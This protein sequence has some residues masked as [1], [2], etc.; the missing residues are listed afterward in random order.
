LQTQKK[1]LAKKK[2]RVKKMKQTQV[3]VLPLIYHPVLRARLLSCC[4]FKRS[5]ACFFFFSFVVG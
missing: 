2:T 5:L 1:T 3:R 4:F